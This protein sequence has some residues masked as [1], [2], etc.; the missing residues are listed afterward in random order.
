MESSVPIEFVLALVFVTAVVAY[1][2]AARRR[3]APR[4]P[5][6]GAALT[7]AAEPRSEPL[8]EP[9]PAPG[10]ALR[11][12]P[13]TPA[14]DS[15]ADRLKAVRA[16]L[17]VEYEA[18]R[19]TSEFAGM[20]RFVAAVAWMCSDAFDT[21]ELFGLY[22]GESLTLACA[23]LAALEQRPDGATVDARVIATMS[24]FASWT[25]TFAL[26][27]LDVHAGSDAYLVPDVLA[28]VDASWNNDYDGR[29]L[30]DFCARRIARGEEPTFGAALHG[31]PGSRLQLL[32][33]LLDRFGTEGEP[34]RVELRAV[35]ATRVD[36]E[37]LQ[38]IGR[39]L[40]A[41]VT[42]EPLPIPHPALEAQARAV[43]AALTAP[44]PRSVVIVGEAGTGKSSVAR[45][46]A[47]R[48]RATGWTIFE[49]TPDELNAG[50]I[51]VGELEGRVQRLVREIDRGRKVLW[52]VRD[53]HTLAWTG[54]TSNSP[55]AALDMLVPVLERG[56]IVLLGETEPAAFEKML[57][58]QPRFAGVI[59]ELRLPPLD[60]AATFSLVRAWAERESKAAGAPQIDDAALHEAWDLARQYLA[61]IAAPG[62]VFHLLKT[63]LRRRR[64]GNDGT[65]AP[66]L[67]L[68]EILAALA[69]LTGLG[70][71]MLDDRAPLDVAA[72]RRFFDEQVIGQPE[73]V[74]CL[75]ER[76]T[77]IK[78]GVTDPRRPL[79]VFLFVGP[80]GTG[81]TELAKALATFLAGTPE[82]MIRID[83]SELMSPEGI[84]RLIGEAG[85]S[86]GHDALTDRIR[87]QPFSVLLLDEFEKAHP[88]VWDLFLQ[89]F[90]DGRLSDRRGRTAD[91]RN[92]IVIM[93]S[94]LGSVIAGSPGV[95]F[96]DESGRFSEQ[97]ALRAV[98]R[99]F[100]KEFLNRIDR[101]VVFRPLER[102]VMRRILS[103][104]LRDVFTRRGLRNR[105]WAVEWDDAALEFLL[106]RGFTPD[107]GARPL[108]RAI[109]RYLLAPL[110]DT[111]VGRRVPEGDQFL[112]VR[113][114]DDALAVTFVDPDAPAATAR[115]PA[116][117]VDG[118]SLA[119]IAVAARGTP[120]EVDAVAVQL[121]ALEA[122][123]EAGEWR[124][125][126]RRELELTGLEDFWNS[127]ERFALLGRIE[128]RDRAER[129]LSSAA[130]LFRRLRGNGRA[131]RELVAP[132]MLSTVAGRLVVIGTACDDLA[133]DRPL[134]AFLMIETPSDVGPKLPRGT[135]DF[136]RRLATMYRRWAAKRGMRLTVLEDTPVRAGFRMLAA[137]SGLGAHTLLAPEDGWHVFE[138]PADGHREFERLQARVRVVPQP[139]E[140]PRGRGDELIDQAR[141]GFSGPAPATATIV[142]R[143]RE[144]PSPLVRDAV[145]GY[146]TGRLSL[147]LDGDFDLITAR[148]G[149]E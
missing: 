23:A 50:Q 83:M 128:Y 93:T 62:N 18:A 46:V 66:A 73:A 38:S 137:A 108:Q 74:E 30:A 77:M 105:N 65:S 145:R 142:R 127:P 126:K 111:I 41:G 119:E 135:V 3:R 72:L 67:A 122:R 4:P 123:I 138:V 118:A 15:K 97:A 7:G 144:Q 25:R 61:G 109:E 147:V 130:S 34:L 49:A 17:D 29:V 89:V 88:M 78:A 31:V 69:Q 54:S 16:E 9:L 125:Q 42:D 56:Q 115:P 53:V 48:M 92:A 63:A 91:F 129:A 10:A 76:V 148:E 55:T 86:H 80:T 79:G 112:F 116:D 26:H 101:V 82:R 134:D 99:A 114:T 110:A 140:P 24:R 5:D 96:T 103:R 60:A 11:E 44:T 21:D 59:D 124:E 84:G 13:P 94:N 95:G 43:V 117:Q 146:R 136:A 100:R 106:E 6:P 87:R 58:R 14:M 113:R 104:Q 45:C 120:A 143:Y 70:A 98:G 75:V 20:P 90:D 39:V 33:E 131:G 47:A 12:A 1:I 28:A 81:K 149:S 71:A 27:M 139:P 2:A 35:Q 68:D 37:Y 40:P 133:Q 107:L 141:R 132:D 8:S 22:S 85:A 57:Q 52:I 32:G 121:E 102:E 64:D 19:T 36:V 51:H